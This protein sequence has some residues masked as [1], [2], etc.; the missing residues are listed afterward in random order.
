M[1]L[2]TRRGSRRAPRPRPWRTPRTWPPVP[3]PSLPRAPRPRPRRS[4]AASTAAPPALRCAPYRRG[5][6]PPP[7]HRARPR[8]RRCL[9]GQRGAARRRL[10]WRRRLLRS[11]PSAMRA[12]VPALSRARW[13]SCAAAA[14]GASVQGSAGV[15]A[16][17]PLGRLRR[18]RAPAPARTSAASL[19]GARAAHAPARADLVS[20]GSR[21]R[22]GRQHELRAVRA[23]MWLR[24]RGVFTRPAPARTR[25][26][27]AAGTR[28]TARSPGPSPLAQ[29]AASSAPP[30]QQQPGSVRVRGAPR[31][32]APAGGEQRGGA[33]DRPHPP[34]RPD[35]CCLCSRRGARSCGPGGRYRPCPRPG[36]ARP[37]GTE[38]ASRAVR[39]AIHRGRDTELPPSI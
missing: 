30:R 1:V 19:S 18:R 4:L 13:G 3:R 27:A 7:Q 21:G 36:D 12:A 14:S 25:T 29:F 8:P 33:E 6:R 39:E 35:T 37:V 26:R 31:S 38:A 34:P 11:A 22:R 28:G 5:K 20:P 24:A 10:T 9:L 23:E 15:A 2:S 32:Q 16:P 17:P